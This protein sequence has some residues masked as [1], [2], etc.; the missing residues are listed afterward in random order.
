MDQ[1]T[2][3]GLIA[4]GES[5]TVG[6][7]RGTIDD[8]ELVAAIV[9][10]ANGDGGQLLLGVE[11]DR[12]ITGTPEDHPNRVHPD[13]LA[14]LV[15]SRTAPGIAVT[16]EIVQIDGKLITVITVPPTDFV[17]GTSDGRFIRRALDVR[18]DPE[19]VPMQ[20]H[21]VVARAAS[22]G[23]A[24]FGRAPLRGAAPDD[25]DPA[26]FERFRALTEAS[27]DTAFA[28][29]SANDILKALN[30]WID[31]ET[32]TAGALLVFGR[33]AAIV[34][35]LPT[36]EVAFAEL[37]GL[38]VRSTWSAHSP[39]FRA[40][41]QLESAINARNP[42]EEIQ[43]GLFRVPLPRFADV[44]VR[45]LLANALTHRDFRE[46]GRVFVQIDEDGLTVSNPGGF[47]DGVRLDN[48]LT[49]PPR[50]RNPTIS[51]AFKR[52]GLVEQVG[53]GINRAFF[54]QLQVGRAA[55]SY[56]RSTSSSV[57]ARLPSGPTD[58]ELAAF[59]AEARRE[60]REFSVDDLLILHAVRTERR[61]STAEA[62]DLL[63]VDRD[64]ARSS[65]NRLVERGLLEARGEARGRTYHLAASVYRRL[66]DA[67]GYV[68]THGFE[69]L[70]QEQMVL[71]YIA[72]NGRITRS[73]AAELCQMDSSQAAR[74]LRRLRAAGSVTMKGSKRGAYYVLPQ[75][76]S[77][78]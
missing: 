49:T 70:Q 1:A 36:H 22:A 74:L 29:L 34:Q 50:P 20:P 63:H 42:S 68:R 4:K 18:G 13:R 69:P 24:D 52:A 57:V 12:S 55:P 77:T 37:E 9:C 26:E 25:L 51:G 32:I 58:R 59:I 39:L 19:C 21:E 62:A 45:E 76:G 47:P 17:A 38:E 61:I 27:G 66:G 73:E 11:D 64:G 30:L 53:R 71:S 23:A 35:Y 5:M 65:L 2:L 54:S 28:R 15:V 40:V 16:A 75:P 7:K 43:I 48:L 10:L 41:E 60:G 14:S 72:N 67:S 46:L 8:R 3:S 78:S 6:F 44:A 33:E 31:D 56:G